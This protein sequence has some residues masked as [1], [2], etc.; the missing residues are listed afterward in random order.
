M[1]GQ[2]LLLLDQLYSLYNKVVHQLASFIMHPSIL[3]AKAFLDG[4]VSAF[5]CPIEDMD[6][7]AELNQTYSAENADIESAVMEYAH[8]SCHALTLALAEALQV[9]QVM[10]LRSGSGL[11]V[12][13]GLLCHRGNLM[14]DANGVHRLEDAHA[15]WARLANEPLSVELMPLSHLVFFYSADEDE[16]AMALEAFECIHSFIEQHCTPRLESADLSM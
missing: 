3:F 8:G 4:K 16:M 12:H 9:D 7:F 14:L 1:H 6:A 15:F 11:P 2:N 13:S 10:V 5:P